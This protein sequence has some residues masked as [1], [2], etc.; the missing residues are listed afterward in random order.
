MIVFYLIGDLPIVRLN[1][2]IYIHG[3]SSL[4]C[5]LFV[6]LLNELHFF[7]NVS[8][9]AN[10][11]NESNAELFQRSGSLSILYFCDID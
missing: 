9:L 3:V 8:L 10:C 7:Q 1:T 5:S 6:L 2:V 11:L 4:I